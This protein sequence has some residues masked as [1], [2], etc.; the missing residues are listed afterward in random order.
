MAMPEKAVVA[1]PIPS[2]GSTVRGTAVGETVSISLLV[3]EHVGPVACTVV[4]GGGKPDQG[5][6]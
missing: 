4:I 5:L 3:G 6:L 2:I 1:I